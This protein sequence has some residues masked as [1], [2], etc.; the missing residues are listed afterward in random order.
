MPTKQQISSHAKK[1]RYSARS[2]SMDLMLD[3]DMLRAAYL[4]REA[5][6]RE[7]RKS[8]LLLQPPA[9]SSQP[10]AIADSK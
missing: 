5:E 4:K 6:A 1:F 8:D 2:R 7:K 3:E 10:G 9:E